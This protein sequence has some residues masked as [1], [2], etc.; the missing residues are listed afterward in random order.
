MKHHS[1][2]LL[3]AI[4]NFK[5]IV[6]S[7][8]SLSIL[9]NIKFDSKGITGTDL[10]IS[11]YIP[12]PN[13]PEICVNYLELINTLKNI[14]GLFELTTDEN[15]LIFTTPSGT[16]KL[17]GMNSDEFPLIPEFKAEQKTIIPSL[18]GYIPFVSTNELKPAMNGVYI[19]KNICATDAHRMKV[20]KINVD[21]NPSDKPF[22]IPTNVAKLIKEPVTCEVSDVNGKLYFENNFIVIFRLIDD[23][24][25][26]YNAVIPQDNPNHFTVLKSDLIQAINRVLPSANKSSNQVKFTFSENELK[27]HTEDIDFARECTQVIP[28]NLVSGESLE[29]G[30][31]GKFMLELIKQVESNEITFEL[32]TGNRA[33][34]INDNT[35]LF[36]LMPVMLEKKVT[37]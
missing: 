3:K 20:S 27:L 14:T 35:G 37:A 11:G 7:R 12:Y 10:E 28:C 6:P 4:S 33:V 15:L 36:L 32:S 1:K 19:G 13:L 22:I 30:F 31:N 9:E 26:D 21:F 18:T 34:V 29:I 5:D 24:Y 17:S 2:L 16:I 8:A 25:P 23:R